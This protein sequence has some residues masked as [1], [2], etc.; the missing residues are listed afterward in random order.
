MKNTL[1]KDVYELHGTASAIMNQDCTLKE[2][3]TRLANEPG[4]RGIFLV[5]QNGRFSG[6]VSRTA[7]IKWAEFQLFSKQQDGDV[8]DEITDMITNIPAR[9]LARGERHSLGVFESDT[10]QKAFEQMVKYGEDVIPV[11]DIEG[12]VTGDLSLPEILLTV[13]DHDKRQSPAS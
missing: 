2:V 6:I 12:R 3:V 11:L 7:I 9:N 13:T 4:T 5:D 10:L 8:P 1:V